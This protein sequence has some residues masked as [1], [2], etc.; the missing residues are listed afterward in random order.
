MW[1]K[2]CCDV[3]GKWAQTIDLLTYL[4]TCWK[5]CSTFRLICEQSS[6]K[7]KKRKMRPILKIA[8]R[9]TKKNTIWL[10]FGPLMFSKI[11]EKCDLYALARNCIPISNLIGFFAWYRV[12]VSFSASEG[13]W[14]SMRNIWLE[15]FWNC[16][17]FYVARVRL[18][19]Y[20]LPPFFQVCVNYFGYM[21]G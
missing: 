11:G 21:G 9:N 15:V 16:L 12:C 3:W 20:N 2:S 14:N 8:F 7:K 4:G 13:K 17:Y 6:V 10:R 5:R 19:L 1:S 18:V